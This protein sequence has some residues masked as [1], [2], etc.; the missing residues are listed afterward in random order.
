MRE[1]EASRVVLRLLPAVVLLSS[2]TGLYEPTAQSTRA[3]D[4]EA[5]PGGTLTIAIA[6]PASIDPGA[7]SDRAGALIASL[8][9]EPLVQIDPLSGEIVNGIIEN[10]VIGRNGSA[11]TI[12]LRDDVKFHN[13]DTMSAQDVAYALSRVAR[14]DFAAPAADVLSPIVGYK[15][16][17]EPPPP[18]ES[19]DPAERT[20]P[21]VRAISSTAIEISLVEPNAEYLRALALPL[22]A[23]IPE[24]LPDENAAFAEQPMCVGP[25]RLA[26]P[27][28]PNDTTIEL[29][30]FDE[31]YAGNAAFSRGGSGYFEVIR[32]EIASD[33]QKELEYFEEGRVEI[34]HVSM[35]DLDDHRAMRRWLLTAPVPEIEFLGVPN[36]TPP[37]DSPEARALLSRALDRDELVTRVFAGGR[38]PADRIVPPGLASQPRPETC[39][40][41]VPP[42]GAD[43]SDRAT[44]AALRAKPYVFKVNDDF[45]NVALAREVVRQWRRKL[46]LDVT[47]SPQPWSEYLSEVT[48]VQGTDAIFRESWAP[49]YPSADAVVQPLFHSDEIGTNNWARVNNATFDRRLERTARRETLPEIRALKYTELEELL[50][51]ELPLIPLTFGQEEYLVRSNKVA[52]ATGRFFDVTTGQPV[53]RELYVRS[54]GSRSEA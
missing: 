34:A 51:R 16:M 13:G 26:R 1:Q 23:P 18:T 14:H 48:S 27:F 4:V 20:L 10:V 33:R 35:E 8:V 11:F 37:F 29:R 50:C 49:A 39:T 41:N 28:R 6:R 32:F 52:A 24:G 5:R 46:R 36:G 42:A 43:T 22:A 54:D 7:V 40:A 38:Q 21:G 3:S 9:C 19:V 31:Y 45:Q 15:E 2:C 17:H 25:Y 44:L 12:R 53:L 30:R 47:V